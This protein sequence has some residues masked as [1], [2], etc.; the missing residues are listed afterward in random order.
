ME[1]ELQF[2]SIFR[3]FFYRNIANTL[4]R[5][6]RMITHDIIFTLSHYSLISSVK[7]VISKM[8]K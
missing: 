5:K 3:F 1:F 4:S 6:V 7:M 8:L 2:P